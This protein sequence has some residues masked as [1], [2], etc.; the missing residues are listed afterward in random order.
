MSGFGV[1]GMSGFGG[2]RANNVKF[3]DGKGLVED[4]TALDFHRNIDVAAD[5]LKV[6]CSVGVGGSIGVGGI[7]GQLMN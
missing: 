1:G 3:D 4:D 5:R 7:V 6:G 2:Q